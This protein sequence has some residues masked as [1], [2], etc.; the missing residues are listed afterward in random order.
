MT[1]TAATAAT[2]NAIQI[3]SKPICLEEEKNCDLN[4]IFPRKLDRNRNSHTLNSF[5]LFIYLH[6]LSSY[7]KQYAN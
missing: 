3:K 1:S 4:E 6:L 2:A 7:V 5:F